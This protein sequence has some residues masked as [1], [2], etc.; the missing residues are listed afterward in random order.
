MRTISAETA[1][2]L[3]TKTINPIIKVVHVNYD[4]LAETVIPNVTGFDISTDVSQFSNNCTITLLNVNPDNI[5]DYGYF[6]PHR[7]D[8]THNKPSNAW[9]KKL[10]P[11]ARIKVYAGYHANDMVPVFY[12][13]VDEVRAVSSSSNPTLTLVC[14]DMGKKLMDQ[15]VN[16]LINDVLTWGM[17]YP[18]PTGCDAVYIAPGEGANYDLS[19][20]VSILEAVRV[21]KEHKLLHRSI[22]VL[23]TIAEEV[24]IRGSDIFDYSII[25]SKEAYVL[26]LDGPVGY[27]AITAPTLLS[28]DATVQGKASHAGFAPELGINAI[29]I[30]AECITQ[31]RQGRIDDNTTVNIGLIEGGKA[32]NIVSDE[33]TLKGEVRSLSH[34]K[35]ASEMMDIKNI[36]ESVT[37]K[38]HAELSF[39]TDIGCLA[40]KTSTEHVVVKRFINACREL[41]YEI[42]LIDTF[43]GSDNNNFMKHGITGIVMACGMNKVHSCNE[44]THI[45]ELEKCCNIVTKLITI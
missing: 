9:Y 18:P 32:R 43:G 24:Y 5:N 27:A 37:E 4:T 17:Q 42:K 6:T 34:D 16:C 30:A 35:A 36:F 22:E 44:Y 31:I 11:N 39:S 21:I 15:N 33:C 45:D 41:G 38:H 12:G 2:I 23:F 3:A 29:A 7:N 10:V 40:Y 26:D 20:I 1:A 13:L 8:S 28:F 25:K 14:R 19:G